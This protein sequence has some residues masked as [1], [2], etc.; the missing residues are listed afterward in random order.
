MLEKIC[1]SH[2][3]SSASHYDKSVVSDSTYQIVIHNHWPT[4][5]FPQP[6]EFFTIFIKSVNSSFML[7]VICDNCKFFVSVKIKIEKCKED[8]ISAFLLRLSTYDNS[9]ILLEWS[10]NAL[11]LSTSLPFAALNCDSTS[12]QLAIIVPISV[13]FCCK[14]LH[15]RP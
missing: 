12:R 15:T 7:I 13:R 10:Y 9:R 3:F 6:T 14:R 2:T 4:I 1:F 11:V 5:C 8:I